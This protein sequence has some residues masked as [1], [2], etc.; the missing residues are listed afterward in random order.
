MDGKVNSAESSGES[1]KNLM[2]EAK[3]RKGTG[4]PKGSLFPFCG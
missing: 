1:Q 4:R 3:A 2:V